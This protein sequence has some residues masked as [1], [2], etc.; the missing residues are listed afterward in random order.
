M[1]T[2]VISAFSILALMAAFALLLIKNVFHGAL[3]LLVVLLSIAGIY[4]M[5]FAEFLAV[6]QIMIYAGGL[7]VLILFGIMLSQRR[8]GK[9]MAVE[10]GR[11]I[12]ALLI[13]GVVFALL[14][15]VRP[16]N[17]TSAISPSPDPIKE[18]GFAMLTD[19]VA[20]FEISGLLLL[21]SLVGAAVIASF[22]IKKSSGHE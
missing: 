8:L 2:L 19:W 10:T 3:L 18:V 20:P 7:L 14:I 22:A 5:L 16:S 6:S 11:I 4:V 9:P 1:Q 12:P 17:S 21:V 13:G 15:Y